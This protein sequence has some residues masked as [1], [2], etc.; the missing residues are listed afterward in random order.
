MIKAGENKKLF[1]A[2][3][4][5]ILLLGIGLRSY[6]YLMGRSMWDDE[7][8]LALN[9]MNH[10]FARLM[11]P[12]DYIQAAPALFILLVKAIVEIFGYSELA[13]RAFP[14]VSS[15]LTLPLIYF[16]TKELTGNSR[17]K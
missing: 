5:T 7:T 16:I 6:Q 4:I 3:F 15:I 11:R 12:L 8:H 14:F 1:K 9:F 10:G 13:F 17:K 2:A